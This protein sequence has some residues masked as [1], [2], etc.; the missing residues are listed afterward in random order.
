MIHFVTFLIFFFLYIDKH[1]QHKFT[2]L[3]CPLS[4]AHPAIP[5]SSIVTEG[6]LG[7]GLFLSPNICR[8]AFLSDRATVHWS[9]FVEAQVL[10]TYLARITVVR[11]AVTFLF[12][13]K[14]VLT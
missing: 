2:R 9:D 8:E 6:R 13:G 14:P 7:F 3:L 10:H 4:Q 12:R 5:D 1:D 11:Y